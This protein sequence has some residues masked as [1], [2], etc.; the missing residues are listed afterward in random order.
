LTLFASVPVVAVVV[1]ARRAQV[2]PEPERL[3]AVAV[4]EEA[5]ESF[6]HSMQPT[7]QPGL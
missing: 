6:K 4:E 3:L 2:E 5:R 7:F 1:V